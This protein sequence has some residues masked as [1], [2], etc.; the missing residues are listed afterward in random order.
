[1][2]QETFNRMC[3]ILFALV[4]IAGFVALVFILEATLAKKEAPKDS[5]LSAQ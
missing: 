3:V 2:K 1:M 5:I 4:F